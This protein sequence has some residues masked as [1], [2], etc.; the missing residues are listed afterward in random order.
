MGAFDE[1]AFRA[2][3]SDLALTGQLL[4]RSR[5]PNGNTRSHR[6]DALGQRVETTD[7][8]GGRTAG[9]S[10]CPA[11]TSH[12]RLAKLQCQAGEGLWMWSVSHV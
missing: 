12:A 8:L 11:G 6:Y 4:L 7:A 10:P 5:A 9:R 2:A 3:G 1:G